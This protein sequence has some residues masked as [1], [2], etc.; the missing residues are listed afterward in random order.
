MKENDSELKRQ[1]AG[2]FATKEYTPVFGSALDNNSMCCW[3]A[4][5]NIFRGNFL[6]DCV[7]QK[8]IAQYLLLARLLNCFHH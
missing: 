2:D 1:L 8:D 3:S 5:N 7:L 6:E 4:A